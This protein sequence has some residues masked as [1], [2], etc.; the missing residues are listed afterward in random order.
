MIHEAEFPH[1]QILTRD[2]LVYRVLLTYVGVSQRSV[3]N[4]KYA[5]KRLAAGD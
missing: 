1:P 4:F 5:L 2:W 3:S